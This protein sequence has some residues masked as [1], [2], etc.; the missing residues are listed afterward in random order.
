MIQFLLN[1]ELV[2]LDDQSGHRPADQTILEYLR[3]ERGHCG[4]KEGCAS[5]DCGACTVVIADKRD[6][7]LYYKSVNSCITFVGALAGRQLITVEHLEQ[8][9]QLHHVQQAM[10][11]HH[12]SQCG[13]C[14][15]GF[16]MSLFALEKQVMLE[17]D[18]PP[19]SPIKRKHGLASWD[20]SP[21]TPTIENYLGG[22]LCRCTGYQPIINAAKEIVAN[23]RSDHFDA[24]EAQ[25]RETLD[26]IQSSLISPDTPKTQ[27]R[28]HIPKNTS[29]IHQIYRMHPEARL[30]VG[31]TDLALEVT[32]QGKTL[33]D[34]ILIDRIR[35]LQMVVNNTKKLEIGAAISLSQ[36]STLLNEFYPDVGELLG[37]F[38]SRQVRNQGS[39]GG[40]IANA[41]PIGD[42]PP[43]LM[44]LSA[45]VKTECPIGEG[46]IEQ[47]IPIDQFFIDYRKTTLEPRGVIISVIIPKPELPEDHQQFVKIYKVSKRLDDDISAVCGAFSITLHDHLVVDAKCAFGGMAAIPKRATHCESALLNQ[48]LSVE[49]MTRAGKMLEQDFTPIDDARASADYRLDVAK[50]LLIRLHLELT[51]GAN[52]TLTRV[53]DYE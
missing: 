37:R 23:P 45:R 14:T 8:N 20:V 27:H 7:R 19:K 50:N 47:A 11:D 48:P 39:I 29:E 36:C 13:F 17:Q 46:V 32:Q 34:I 51:D 12:G 26:T 38:G 2:T 33:E 6:D 25:T 35:E 30:V 21:E 10:V 44:A 52:N 1:D 3:N 49:T 22:N 9:G 5:G 43:V 42:L 16:I 24:R 41:S 18:P 28:F 31:G 4:T 15:P 53:T 40:N